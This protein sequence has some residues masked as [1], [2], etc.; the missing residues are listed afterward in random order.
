ME[1]AKPKLVTAG[2]VIQHNLWFN[3]VQKMWKDCSE[4]SD[5]IEKIKSELAELRSDESTKYR[6][7]RVVYRLE[8]ELP[9]FDKED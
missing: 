6:E 8:T 5:S 7:Y 4:V 9:G 1:F 3:K 2:F